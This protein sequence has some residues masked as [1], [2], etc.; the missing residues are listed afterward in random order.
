M[1]KTVEAVDLFCGA[2]GLSYGL[3]QGGITVRAGVDLDPNC[4]YPFEEN[5]RADFHE[6]SVRDLTSDQLQSMWSGRALRLLA[7]CAPCQPFS[8]QRRGQ[9]A[10]THES[11]DLLLEFK[12]LVQATRPD[13]VTME[14][15]TRLQRQYVFH[16]FVSGLLDAGYYVDFKPMYANEYGLAQRRRR[17][18]LIASRHGPIHLPTP[19]HS[20]ERQVTVS[21]AIGQLPPLE[22]GE[23]SRSDPLH[24]ARRL[25]DINLARIRASKPG[26][27]WRDWPEALRA[28]CQNR[29]TGQSFGSFYGVM[30]P[31][32]PAPTITTE[33]YNYG[34]GRFGHP[35]QPRTIT[36]REA[37][38]LQGFPRDYKFVP[39]AEDPKFSVL[40][41][42]I[43]NAVPPIFGELIAQTINNH[44]T[45]KRT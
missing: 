31:N 14:N 9:E 39:R 2:G 26:G 41:R 21:E 15:V 29:S 18:V 5:I 8:S 19:T 37:A 1:A 34:S 42:M 25:T 27:T 10:K 17:L 35:S 38:I 16:S 6:M 22:A 45:S 36:P 40:G 7:G 13:F 43:G 20:R 44:N 30:V 28:P 23:A 11:W 12:R 3:Q 24:R 4:R 32:E 33:F